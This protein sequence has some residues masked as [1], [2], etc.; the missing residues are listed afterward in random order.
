MMT[1]TLRRTNTVQWIVDN[2]NDLA[3]RFAGDAEPYPTSSEVF[4]ATG[5]A[6]EVQA[7]FVKDDPRLHWLAQQFVNIHK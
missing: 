4:H 1:A 6:R 5:L 3:S 7:L 2:L